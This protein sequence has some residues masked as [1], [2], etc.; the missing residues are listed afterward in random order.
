MKIRCLP[1]VLIL[2]SCLASS[3]AAQDKWIGVRTRNFY[4]IGNASE[5]DIRAAGSRLEQFRE[6]FRLIFPA[7]KVSSPL[8]T[9]VVVFQSPAAYLPFKPK[10]TDGKPDPD[11]AGYFQPGEDVNYITLSAGTKDG[12]GTIFHEYVHFLLETNFPKSDIPPWLNEGLAEYFQTFRIENDQTITLGDAQPGHLRLLRQAPLIPLKDFFAVDNYSLHQ[13]GNHS[14]SLF[15]AQAWLAIHYLT[16]AEGGSSNEAFGKF[17]KLVTA[18]T[19]HETALRQTFNMSYADLEAGLRNYTTRKNLTGTANTLP[20]KMSFDAE[21]TTASLSPAQVNAYLGDLLYHLRDYAGAEEHLAMALDADPNLSTANASLGLVRMQQRRFADAKKYLERAI[22]A[23]GR[24]YLAHFNYAYVLSRE[25]MDE[26]GFIETFP[27]ENARRMRESLKKAIDLNPEFSES[28]RLL[29]F[30]Y[31]T[32]GDSLDEALALLKKGSLL[33]P[34][35][36]EYELLEAQIYLR[37]EKFE[38]A[39]TIAERLLKTAED[40]PT[41]RDAQEIIDSTRQ[42][43]E[44]KRAVRDQAVMVEIKGERTPLILKRETLTEAEIARIE[45]E[46][47]NTNLNRLLGKLESGERRI[48]GHIDKVTCAG[49]EVSY[50]VRSDGVTAMLVSK[51]FQSLKMSVLKEGTQSFKIGCGVSLKDELLVMTFRPAAYAK[52]ELR[53]IV[54][55]PKTFELMTAEEIAA[56]RWVVIEGGP[57]TDIS[58]NAETAAK[59][60]AEFERQRRETMLLQITES[61]RTPLEGETRII[62]TV[63]RIECSNGASKFSIRSGDASFILNAPLPKEIKPVIFTPDAD[64][65]QF[66]CDVSLPPVNAVITYR[67]GKGGGDLV[68]LEFVPKSFRLN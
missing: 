23:D 26:F 42:Y 35:S 10:R 61:L 8:P 67:P 57:A 65:I 27:P 5:A 13:N 9:N 59:E 34:G 66:G 37:Q 24:N 50:A 2:V 3:V 6:S 54:F 68:S 11:I 62:G 44:A 36:Q 17:L 4:L 43:A 47:E 60:Q 40:K 56:A 55:V 18:K 19:D 38:A 16:H 48:V 32:N 1:I 25:S 49:D 41:R 52:G 21:M 51:D 22:A 46:R 29:A 58:K 53:S 33:N 45:R 64:R 15:Y 39:K 31:M 30:L 12:Y 28:Y 14:R 20:K 7:V 63:E